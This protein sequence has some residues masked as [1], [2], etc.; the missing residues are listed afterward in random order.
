M[1]ESE[2]L[3]FRYV[4]FIGNWSGRLSLQG[5]VTSEFH[6]SMK[7][8]SSSTMSYR[9]SFEML[10]RDTGVRKT[11]GQSFGTD[12]HA[13]NKMTYFIPKSQLLLL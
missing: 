1:E 8:L 3:L 7:D 6:L 9:S 4:H 13:L 5:W 12:K 11:K 2:A 10:K